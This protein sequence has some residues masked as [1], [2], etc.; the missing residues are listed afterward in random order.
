MRRALQEKALALVGR[1]TTKDLSA[2]EE[3]L[4]RV[5]GEL[6]LSVA[7]AIARATERD[8]LVY[9][10]L[11]SALTVGE[12]YFFRHPEHFELLAEFARARADAGRPLRNVWSVGCSTGEEAYSLALALHPHAPNLEVLGS[13]GSAS[14][15]EVARKALRRDGTTSVDLG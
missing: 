2:V 7:E 15:L 9:P 10:A 13:D 14:S 4:H 1:R 12:T 3:A 6:G 8:P 5:S 11:V